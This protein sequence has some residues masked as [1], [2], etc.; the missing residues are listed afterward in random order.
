MFPH[1]IHYIFVH[2]SIFLKRD[3]AENKSKST[4][5]RKVEFINQTPLSE[6]LF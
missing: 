3:S 6:A 4:H 1:G 5:S 2:F